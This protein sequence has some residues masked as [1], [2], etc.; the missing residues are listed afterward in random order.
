MNSIKV[1]GSGCSNCVKLEQ[2]SREAVKELGLDFSIEKVM[3]F[4]AI[5]KRGI[6]RTPG[7]EI[8]GK[9]VSMGQIPAKSTLLSWIQENSNA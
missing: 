3:D 9:I 2:M 4:E 7:L 6:I 1:Y 8:N 5:A